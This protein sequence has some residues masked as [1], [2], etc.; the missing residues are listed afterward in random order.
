LLGRDQRLKSASISGG[1]PK[2][3]LIDFV[4]KKQTDNLD[5]LSE[6]LLSTYSQLAQKR[7]LIVDDEAD[8]ASIGYL[9]D[10]AFGLQL[11]TIAEKVDELRRSPTKASPVSVRRSSHSSPL[12]VSVGFRTSRLN[13]DRNALLSSFRLLPVRPPTHGR[14][15]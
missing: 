13:A 14:K 6:A 9:Q 4:V 15:V 12:A 3:L 5:R 7:I 1:N 8:N 2:M 11:R 10:K